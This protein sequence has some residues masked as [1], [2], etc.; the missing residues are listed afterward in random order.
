MMSRPRWIPLL[1]LGVL[2]AALL[3][4]A[5]TATAGKVI[6]AKSTVTISSGA[7]TVFTGTVSSSQKK[8]KADRSV[9]LFY[10]VG[11]N[12]K[13]IDITK[14]NSSG[15]WGMHGRFAAGM[16]H[17]QV[18]GTTIHTPRVDIHCLG[19]VSISARF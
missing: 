5:G 12:D 2:S 1:A 15:N 13:V 6:N 9:K 16:Y 17:A 18:G 8:C 14:T 7:G 11:G 3:P 4:A 10:E 19:D